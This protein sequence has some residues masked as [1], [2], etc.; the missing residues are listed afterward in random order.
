MAP[1]TA[2]TSAWAQPKQ[3]ARRAESGYI[4]SGTGTEE[5]DH[6]RREANLSEKQTR[7]RASEHFTRGINLYK[8]GDYRAAIQEWV[9][10]YCHIRH[11]DTLKNISE[12]YERLVD[13]EKAVAYLERYIMENPPEAVSERRTQAAYVE[14]L[15]NLEAH[16]SIA[17][18]P[19]G[20]SVTLTG[21]TGVSAEGMSDADEPLGVRKGTYVMTIEKEGYETVTKTISVKIGKP[22]SYYFRLPPKKGSLHVIA[23]PSTAT[24]FINERR[25]DVGRYFADLPVGTYEVSAEVPGRQPQRQKVEITEG[26]LEQVTLELK[27]KPRSGRLDLLLAATVGGAWAGSSVAALLSDRGE[28]V[29]GGLPLGLAIGFGGAY[30]GVPDRISVGTSSYLIGTTIMGGFGGGILASQF[31]CATKEDGSQGECDDEMLIAAALAGGVG[32]FLTGALTTDIVKLNAGDAALINSGAL[33]GSTAGSLFWVVFN[34]DQQL[35]APLNLAGLTL[36]VLTGSLL[37]RNAE[38]RRRHVA[39]IDVSGALG[40][41]VGAAIADVADQGEGI[42]ERIPHFALLGMTVGLITGTYLTRNMDEPP[43][44]GSISPSVGAARD[45]QG[46]ATMT[47]GVTGR[48]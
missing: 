35:A 10:S 21:E 39:L 40:L 9:L 18:D 33:W 15:R 43:S 46:D 47:M 13:Y 1:A 37:A 5:L 26:G 19:K 23:V 4:G 28:I 24:I 17:T 34:R 11:E 32:G 48:F 42:S 16:V 38:V 27:R 7:E 22:Y 3:D 8:Q 25:V 2:P 30:L 44:L 45:A 41:L 36:G 20:A 31:A 12:A 6:C 29:G 14:V